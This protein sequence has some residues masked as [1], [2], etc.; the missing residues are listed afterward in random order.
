MNGNI[1][2]VTGESVVL[3]SA[4]EGSPLHCEHADSFED[5]R[6]RIYVREFT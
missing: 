4:A 1:Y 3:G 5:F 2:S 6:S